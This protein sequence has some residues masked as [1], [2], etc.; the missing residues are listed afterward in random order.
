MLSFLPM[1][2][3]VCCRFFLW[4][5][6]YVFV[7]SY[8][9]T[10]MFS[11]LPME[12]PV[13]FFT[14]ALF[15]LA[16]IFGLVC[17][18]H[19][20]F[21]RKLIQSEWEEYFGD[22]FEAYKGHFDG[23]NTT[24]TTIPPLPEMVSTKLDY[25]YYIEFIT[26]AYFTV[27]IITRFVLFPYKYTSFFCDFLNLVDIF[28][29]VVMFSIYFA[30]LANPKDKYEA[31]IYDIIHCLQIVRIF[32]LFRLVK[33]LT[34]FRVLM[35]AV[36]ASGL[37]VLLMSMFFVVGM[38]MFG[39]FAFFSG[40]T[41]FPSIPDSFW[42]AVV[43]MTTV[44]YGDMVPTIGLSKCIGGLCAITGVCLLSITI[45]IFVNNFVMFTTIQKV[46]RTASEKGYANVSKT[47]QHS[48]HKAVPHT[49]ETPQPV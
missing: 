4:S 20:S 46:W 12:L 11:F 40:D 15:V 9:V 7:S 21:R 41:A 25:L 5:Y 47:R 6:Q 27:E 44:G 8:G 39:A 13:Y 3:P 35:Y 18:T 16:S 28:S 33:N 22:D 23:S 1:E 37:E 14:S 38:L 42:W 19:S 26:V 32:R 17:Q 2:L 31:S 48:S 43:T 49:K 30:N 29:L 34:G 24:N 45:P 36:R 10:S